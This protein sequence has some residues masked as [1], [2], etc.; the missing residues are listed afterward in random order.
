MMTVH[1]ISRLSGVSIRTL[2]YYD[3]IGLLMPAGT[4]EAGYRLYDENSLEKL[5]QILFFRELEFSLKEIGKIVNRPGFDRDK[6]LSQQIELLTLKKE[7]IEALI[8]L[9]ETSRQK[10]ERK[11]QFDAFDTKKM[12]EY[13]NR[14]KAAWGQTAAYREYEKKAG[15]RGLTENASLADRM[16]QIFTEFG[17]IRDLDS[18]SAPAQELV[19]KLQQFITAHYYTC[20]EEI[21]SEL[22]RLY[23]AG[24][25]FTENIDRAGGPGTAVFAATAI[26]H[27]CRKE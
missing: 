4:T 26:E 27:F 19:G 11:M 13:A 9:A 23:A 14:A 25:E 18:A 10:G 20:T 1:E 16:M 8:E 24:G 2:Q 3:K 7:R 5:Q 6:A 17:T 15:E 12:K 22:G 21:L